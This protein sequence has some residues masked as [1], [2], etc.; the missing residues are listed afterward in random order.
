MGYAV[1]LYFDRQTEECILDLRRALSEACS[2][3]S[4]DSMGVRPHI[5]LAGFSEVEPDA[6]LSLVEEYARGLE[7]FAVQFSAIGIFPT[8]ENVLFLSP[9]PTSQLL[10][11]HQ[12]FRRQLA[13]SGL[14]PSL[15]YA[16]DNWVPH[17][18]VGMNIPNEQFY[19]A[20]EFCQTAF[21][22]LAGVFQEIGV[23]EYWPLK[24]L[25]TWPFHPD[26]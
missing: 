2:L 6:L 17:C 23:I 24:P 11:H 22:P 26:R 8:P 4:S 25:G 3:S 18:T 7:P 12:E 14:S 1:L 19:Q 15:Y 10:T 20:L 13:R 5:S 9:V 16:P 21:E